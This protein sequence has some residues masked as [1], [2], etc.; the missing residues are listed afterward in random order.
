M[1]THPA[2]LKRSPVPL[3]IVC[4][5]PCSGKTSYVQEHAD[6][7]ADVIID[8]DSIYRRIKPTYRHWETRYQDYKLMHRGLRIRNMMLAGLQKRTS[9]KAWFI[10]SAPTQKERDWWAKQLGGVVVLLNPGI[11]ECKRR[12]HARGT[13]IAVTGIDRWY[14]KSERHWHP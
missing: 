7:K 6:Y 11:T 12:A 13:P 1:E 10:V 8:L 5:P 3:T 4:G 14:I 9:G 2:W